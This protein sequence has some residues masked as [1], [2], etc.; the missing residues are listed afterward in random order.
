MCDEIRVKLTA[1]STGSE[2][3]AHTVKEPISHW[4]C[5]QTSHAFSMGSF[6]VLLSKAEGVFCKYRMIQVF[7]RMYAVHGGVFVRDL[8]QSILTS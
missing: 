1:Q 2:C 5:D 6:Q 8:S 3:S 7:A 4:R